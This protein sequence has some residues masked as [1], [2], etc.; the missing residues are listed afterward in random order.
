MNFAW[1]CEVSFDEYQCGEEET[2][3]FAKEET[4][5]EEE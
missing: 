5:I 3:E 1:T 2:S 4:E